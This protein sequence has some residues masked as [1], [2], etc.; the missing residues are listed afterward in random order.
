MGLKDRVRIDKAIP[1][2]QTQQ[3][4]AGQFWDAVTGSCL[5]KWTVGMNACNESTRILVGLAPA[6][7]DLDIDLVET[8]TIEAR[9]HPDIHVDVFDV[10]GLDSA[11][12][13]Q[14]IPE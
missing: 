11:D 5:H 7:S 8:M 12:L 10:S 9:K 1:P 13:Q 14:Y 3:L 2:E 6:Y 4:R